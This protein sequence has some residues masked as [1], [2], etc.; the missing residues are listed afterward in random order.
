MDSGMDSGREM[1]T[2]C[3]Y[4]NKRGLICPLWDGG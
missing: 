4:K 3:P 2:D 1:C